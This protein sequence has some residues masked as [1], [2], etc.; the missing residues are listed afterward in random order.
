M[1]AAAAAAPRRVRAALV[2]LNGTLH[3]GDA[4]IAGGPTAL[5]RLR[6]AGV[7][8]V[9]VTNTTKARGQG[10]CG[11]LPAG[12]RH[13]GGATGLQG[14]ASG[15]LSS[16]APLLLPAHAARSHPPR[17]LHPPLEQD[18]ISNLLGLVQGLGYRIE[19]G[20]VFSSLTATRRLLEARRLRP[21]LLLHP[22]ALPDFAGLDTADPNCGAPVGWLAELGDW[23]TC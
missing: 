23:S 13:A 2:D 8:T 17:R 12:A 1:A 11:A 14:G 21:Y 18:T 5:E 10:S 3:V 15:C 19:R 7:A 20:E 22:N 9:F 16:A 4:A 6:A